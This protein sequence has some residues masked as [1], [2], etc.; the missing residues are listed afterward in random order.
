M[1]LA[2]FN[3]PAT[4]FCNQSCFNVLS[5]VYECHPLYSQNKIF[6]VDLQNNNIVENFQCVIVCIHKRCRWQ[7]WS[8]TEGVAVIHVPSIQQA[9]NSELAEQQYSTTLSLCDCLHTKGVVVR[10]WQHWP[11]Q[12]VLYIYMYT[13]CT[14]SSKQRLATFL[15]RKEQSGQVPGATL[16]PTTNF[17]VNIFSSIQYLVFNI[18]YNI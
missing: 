12:R 15:Q 11:T 10:H 9:A 18:W 4:S 8:K 16:P 7:H 14:T 5:N 1:L 17:S 2:R 3:H 6:Y 13:Q